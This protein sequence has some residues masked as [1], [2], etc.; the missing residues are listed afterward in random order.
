MFIDSYM[1]GTQF[2][3]PKAAQDIAGFEQEE[4]VMYDHIRQGIDRSIIEWMD[5]LKLFHIED[6]NVFAHAFYD[7]KRSPDDQLTRDSVWMRM[8]DWMTFQN[9]NQGLYLTHGHTPRKHG[10]VQSPNRTNLDAGAVFYGRFV[11]AEYHKDIQ[12]PVAFHEFGNK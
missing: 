7:D 12:G 1:N 3:D 2:Y 9:S 4:F 8:D 5:N 11:I 6:K 10:P